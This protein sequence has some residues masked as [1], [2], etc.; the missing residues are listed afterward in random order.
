MAY[1]LY[2][3][4]IDRIPVTGAMNYMHW[5]AMLYFK[6]IGV[7]WYDFVGSR[8]NPEK[9]SKFE[10]IQRFKKRFGLDF[11]IGYIWTATLKP[12]KYFMFC[13]LR[14][15]KNKQIYKDIVEQELN[16]GRK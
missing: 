3:D 8:V 14:S 6:N 11:R 5:I 7:Q 16:G 1:Y 13:C 2:S 15:L 9:G 4:F 10:D 12:V